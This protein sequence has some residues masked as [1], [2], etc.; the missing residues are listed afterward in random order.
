VYALHVQEVLPPRSSFDRLRSAACRLL[1]AAEHTDGLN[2]NPTSPE[3]WGARP[4]LSQ[5]HA[6]A[7]EQYPA[8]GC[9]PVCPALVAAHQQHYHSHDTPRPLPDAWTGGP[10]GSQSKNR[11][12]QLARFEESEVPFPASTRCVA[13]EPVRCPQRVLVEYANR[14]HTGARQAHRGYIAA[15]HQFVRE[16]VSPLVDWAQSVE[17]EAGAVCLSPPRTTDFVRPWDVNTGMQL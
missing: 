4:P 7:P 13:G 8:D 6:R 15:Y 11:K 9:P 3:Q 17:A 14:V 12:Q 5:L 16:V 1:A 10:E 2:C